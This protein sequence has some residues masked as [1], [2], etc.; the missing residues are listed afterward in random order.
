VCLS[1][2]FSILKLTTGTVRRVTI[3]MC[4]GYRVTIGMC[5]GYCER[6]LEMAVF[7]VV[8]LAAFT[9]DIEHALEQLCKVHVR[10][11]DQGDLW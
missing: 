9:D 11:R 10:V 5:S 8:A 4:S 1:A 6:D 2:R 7:V 3:G